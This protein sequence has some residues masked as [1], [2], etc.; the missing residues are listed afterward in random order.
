[1]QLLNL[2]AI[3]IK[4]SVFRKKSLFFRWIPGRDRPEHER[5]GFAASSIDY[6][7]LS[8]RSTEGEP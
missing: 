6:V 1:M 2:I 4:K 8:L 3:K 7:T 5:T